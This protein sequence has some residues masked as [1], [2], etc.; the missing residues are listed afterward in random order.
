MKIYISGPMTGHADFNYPA[1][2]AAA[3][4]GRTVV[5]EVDYGY[6][7]AIGEFFIPANARLTA[8]ARSDVP[9]LVAEVRAL[10][11]EV[12]RWKRRLLRTEA[13][14]VAEHA[15]IHHWAEEI[16]DRCGDDWDH[17]GGCCTGDAS[18]CALCRILHATRPEEE[19]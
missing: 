18:G 15:S 9:R 10:R 14:R 19:R 8:A 16:A 3:Q 1:F 13:L 5:Y 12:E 7:I 17:D 4:T 6:D 11:A 2:E